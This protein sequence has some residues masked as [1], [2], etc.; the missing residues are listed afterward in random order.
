MSLRVCRKFLEAAPLHFQ[1]NIFIEVSNKSMKRKLASLLVDHL[2]PLPF[3]LL[4]SLE[5]ILEVFMWDCVRL[6]YSLMEA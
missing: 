2:S 1:I 6:M 5:G 4:L 3:H